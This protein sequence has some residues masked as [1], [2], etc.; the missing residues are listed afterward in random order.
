MWQTVA[1]R[2]LPGRLL[3]AL[4]LATLI[5]A[6][7]AA[8]TQQTTPDQA[9]TP[10]SEASA[11]NPEFHLTS[12]NVGDLRLVERRYQEAIE[13][14]QRAPHNSAA[15]W[16]KM[17]IA[18]QMLFDLKDAA[19][20]YRESLRMNPQNAH[21]WN[22]LGTIYDAQ[23]EYGKAERMYRE[24]RKIDPG[25]AEYAMNLGTNLMV[26]NKHSEGWKMYQLALALNPKIFDD[27]D[28]SVAWNALTPRE[29]GAIHY[30]QAKGYAE[31][32]MSDEAIRAL[33]K[34]MNEGFASPEQISRDKSFDPLHGNPRYRQMMADRQ[35][36]QAR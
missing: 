27:P 14:Y 16:N 21:A 1:E 25:S 30:F 28:A 6:P 2:R 8:K 15:V 11:A 10:A 3:P 5:S 12:E 20:C 32:G 4:L 9:A 18:Y 26:Q 36:R 31:A 13:A 35:K 19:H 33:Q 23:K 22:N 17:G 34:A 29:N 24:A 7:L